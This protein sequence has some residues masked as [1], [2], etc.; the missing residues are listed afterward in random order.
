VRNLFLIKF[1]RTSVLTTN[2][3]QLDNIRRIDRLSPIN[4][5]QCLVNQSRNLSTG[6]LR[7]RRSPIARRIV[8]HNIQISC[9]GDRTHSKIRNHRSIA[10][11]FQ[12][13]R[14]VGFKFQTVNQ[15]HD[16]LT[17][18]QILIRAQLQPRKPRQKPPREARSIALLCRGST[19][20][21]FLPDFA[22][23][24]SSFWVNAY[25]LASAME[26]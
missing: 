19:L 10:V 22:A 16:R 6:N 2:Q 24:Y 18:S 15:R 25:Q 20:Y 12:R 11:N 13:I 9:C 14:I 23:T 7:Q 4:C 1:A 8:Y 17:L 3:L 5:H 21:S 26:R